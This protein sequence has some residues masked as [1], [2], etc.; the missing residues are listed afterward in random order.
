MMSDTASI[1]Q[2][3][4]SQRELA[5]I[6]VSVCYQ[7]EAIHEPSVVYFVISISLD[8]LFNVY[9]LWWFLEIL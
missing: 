7:R 9:A 1:K 6:F 4:I 5:T 3:I 8:A 2:F